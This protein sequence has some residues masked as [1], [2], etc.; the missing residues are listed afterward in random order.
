METS[1]RIGAEFMR[2]DIYICYD[3]DLDATCSPFEV[4]AS[5]ELTAHFQA[6]VV[7]ALVQ[8][9][10]RFVGVRKILHSK[11]FRFNGR[12]VRIPR[13]GTQINTLLDS[14]APVPNGC[15]AVQNPCGYVASGIGIRR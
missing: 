12:W 1:Y 8:P 14:P 3:E 15:D 9:P 6:V 11:P 2:L 10:A 7:D 4:V 5:G 13:A